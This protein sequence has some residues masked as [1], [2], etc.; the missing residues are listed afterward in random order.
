MRGCIH[1]HGESWTHAASSSPSLRAQRSNPDCLVDRD[2]LVYRITGAFL[3]DAASAIG[4]VLDGIADKRK[5]LVVDFA[6][7]PFLDST[8]ANVLGRVAAKA[9]RRGIRLLITGASPAVRRALLTLGVTPPRARYRVTIA[10]AV[11]DIKG[12]AALSAADDMA[13]T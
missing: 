9:H 3:F 2:V 4:S 5:G 6:A 7:V 12:G 11:A 10:R 1:A 8:A 13:A